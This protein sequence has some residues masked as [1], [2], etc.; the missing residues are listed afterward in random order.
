MV[1]YRDFSD[2]TTDKKNPF[3]EL[4]IPKNLSVIEKRK[5]LSELYAKWNALQTHSNTDIR[6]EAEEKL[7]YIVECKQILKKICNLQQPLTW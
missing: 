6:K 7:K 4:N 2:K 1:E 5:R 3:S